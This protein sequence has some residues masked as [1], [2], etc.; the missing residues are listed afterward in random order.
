MKCELLIIIVYYNEKDYV[1]DFEK[2]KVYLNSVV[3]AVSRCQP[4]IGLVNGTVYTVYTYSGSPF[5]KLENDLQSN[6]WALHHTCLRCYYYYLQGSWGQMY[7]RD[8]QTK[9]CW[10]SKVDL[11][12]APENC[13][14]NVMACKLSENS[15]A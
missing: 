5:V 13:W 10:R 7:S 12:A 2:N 8:A 14:M 3:R 11:E 15:R 6:L 1:Y 4:S 9:R